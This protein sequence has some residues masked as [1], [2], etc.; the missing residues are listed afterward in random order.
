MYSIEKY[1]TAIK[2]AIK[3]PKLSKKNLTLFSYCDIM[4]SALLCGAMLIF[5]AKNYISL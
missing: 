1:F 3:F 5:R 4:D 2:K